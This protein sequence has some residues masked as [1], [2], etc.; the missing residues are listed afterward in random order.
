MADYPSPVDPDFIT[1]GRAADLIVEADPC[2]TL[3]Q[4]TEFFK[5]AVFAGKFDA[6]LGAV[7]WP[8]QEP[9]QIEVTMPAAEQTEGQLALETRPTRLYEMNRDSIASVI[10]CEAGLPG[11]QDILDRWFYRE[12]KKEEV[13]DHLVNSPLTKFPEIGQKMIADIRISRTRLK[14][15]LSDHDRPVPPG[16]G[17][18]LPGSMTSSNAKFEAAARND[19]GPKPLGRPELLA[20]SAVRDH[21]ARIY[22]ADPSRPL[23]ALAHEARGEAL[24]SF[25]EYDVP[26]E[27]TILRRMKE[28]LHN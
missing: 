7:R 13:F 17:P 12:G 18:A 27:T 1:L 11:R 20:W 4:V 26:S 15:W 28:I 9:L 16:L 24:K 19:N 14:A 10:F 22:D 23:K 2:L 3:R 25:A 21:V 5:C 6:P 8:G